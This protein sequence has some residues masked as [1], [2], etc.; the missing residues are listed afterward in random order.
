MSTTF[1]VRIWEIRTVAGRR[2]PYG[3]RWITDKREHSEWFKLK[4]QANSRRSELMKAARDGEP[5]DVETG[6]PMSE[7]N[8]GTRCHFSNSPRSTWT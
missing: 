1:Q 8:G 7:L 5:F 2:R 4:A 3:V 6:L